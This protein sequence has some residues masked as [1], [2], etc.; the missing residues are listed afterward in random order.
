MLDVLR[1]ENRAAIPYGSIFR[2][3]A[4]AQLAIAGSSLWALVHGDNA[5]RH[6]GSQGTIDAMPPVAGD[7]PEPCFLSR[8][9]KVD[10]VVQ[11]VGI[12]VLI[13]HDLERHT[14][15]FRVMQHGTMLEKD[16]PRSV[17][18]VLPLIEAAALRLGTAPSGPFKYGRLATRLTRY[19][20]TSPTRQPHAFCA[21]HT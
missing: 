17:V 16:P 11:N 15:L 21:T 20:S 9:R 3:I 2:V 13:D 14:E 6:S 4:A 10:V 8:K 19:G 18:D 1:A 7:F 5:C 12:V